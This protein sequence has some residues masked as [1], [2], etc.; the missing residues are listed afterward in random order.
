MPRRAS[1]FFMSK[2][3]VDIERLRMK[4]HEIHRMTGFLEAYG[5]CAELGIIAH[6]LATG[7]RR[8]VILM[9]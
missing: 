9:R 2:K 5:Y 6:D 8:L 1:C 3:T 7:M 4:H